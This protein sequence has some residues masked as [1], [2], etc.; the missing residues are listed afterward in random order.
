MPSFSICSMIRAAH[1]G[2]GGGD[3]GGRPLRQRD[4]HRVPPDPAQSRSGSVDV[5][6]R[7]RRRRRRDRPGNAARALRPSRR[8]A[9][10]FLSVS[11]AI[12]RFGAGIRY[13]TAGRSSLR[14]RSRRLL[15]GAHREAAPD[16]QRIRGGVSKS[17][18]GQRNFG[19]GWVLSAPRPVSTRPRA[20]IKQWFTVVDAPPRRLTPLRRLLASP[21]LKG[22]QLREVRRSTVRLRRLQAGLRRGFLQSA[23]PKH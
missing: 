11:P 17:S 22:H 7:A 8:L 13:L 19:W 9:A 18:C 14:T 20:L 2:R 21:A 3:P 10:Q 6:V 16:A 15:A 1:D 23:P 12:C 4:P 5:R